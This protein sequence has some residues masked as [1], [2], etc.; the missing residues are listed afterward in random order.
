M[1]I[2]DKIK[3]MTNSNDPQYDD[4][5]DDDYYGEFDGPDGDG[6]EY[7]VDDGSQ[8]AQG[9]QGGMS[10]LN[11]AGSSVEMKIVKPDSYSSAAPIAS[12]LLNK[13]TVF[14]NLE[15]ADK[16]TAR[17]LIDFLAG[18]SFAIGGQIKKTSAVT[19]VIAPDCV[20]VSD[21]KLAA[22]RRKSQAQQDDE[23]YSDV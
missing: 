20:D 5:Y 13:R 15:N 22:N 16:E 12:H 11:I 9:A 3:K 23:E 17:K 19:Y 21:D 7:G 6:D 1:G 2:V 14:L 18:V 4:N 10:G 8:S